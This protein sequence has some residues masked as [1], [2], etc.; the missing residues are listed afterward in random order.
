[1]ANSTIH[2]HARRN[3]T[4]PGQAALYEQLHDTLASDALVRRAQKRIFGP[5][6]TELA[7]LFDIKHVSLRS[8]V[9]AAIAELFW[10]RYHDVERCQI[11]GM[12]TAALP[13]IAAIVLEGTHRGRDV[14]GFYIR[15]SRKKAGLVKQIEGATTD[16][17]VILV[18]D[19]INTG[20]SFERQ[21]QLLQAEGLV[22]RSVFAVVRFREDAAYRHILDRGIGVDAL[23]ALPDF[24]I[25]YQEAAAPDGARFTLD[26]YFKSTDAS[27]VHVR[28]KSLPLVSGD[29]IYYAADNGHVWCLA[30][31]ELRVVWHTK[32]GLFTKQHVFATP[33]LVEDALI[34]ASYGG[35]VYRLDVQSGKILCRR[36]V[37]ERITA[38][39]LPLGG[40]AILV[41]TD[42]R[43][44]GTLAALD[45]CTLDI[46]WSH[47]TGAPVI[48][49]G[50]T[51]DDGHCIVSDSAGTFYWTSPT[52]IV[53]T[54]HWSPGGAAPGALGL[55]TARRR[56]VWGTADGDLIATPIDGG[57]PG[58][59]FRADGGISA[60]PCTHGNMLLAGSLD[61]NVYCLDLGTNKLRWHYET[62]GS[63]FASPVV[64]D[65]VVYVG[66]NDGRLYALDH[67][68][69]TELG[70][71]QTTERVTSPVVIDD[72]GTIFLT[73][74]ANE[75]YTLPVRG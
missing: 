8:D 26:R 71:F 16:A 41:G 52:G 23:Y 12:E 66:S 74:F 5:D 57:R 18:D 42:E 22:V 48:A 65:G 4:A 60:A 24:G 17:S 46:L 13:L 19:L 72:A 1:M 20:K 38:D 10:E 64:H 14:S 28:S 54:Q 31:E 25:A 45:P 43:T 47:P 53:Q 50:V 21:I 29:R 63:V 58:M 55:D 70:H 2:N 61:G 6:E 51:L 37:G 75:I 35:N 39:P 69:G 27:H 3:R 44:A 32:L 62:R 15:K 36:T 73:T 40:H 56:I 11:G 68:T 67:Q 59:V 9:L 49:T 30:R 34:V 33:L 7:W